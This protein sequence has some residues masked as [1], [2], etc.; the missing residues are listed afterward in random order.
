MRYTIPNLTKIMQ[1]R[2]AHR[3]GYGFKGSEESKLDALEQGTTPQDKDILRKL[4][5]KKG[6]KV[7]SIAGYYAS[8]AKE[9]QRAGA[10]VDYSD[11]SKGIVNWVKN[12][13]KVK[14]GKYLCSNYE[15]IP[16]NELEYDWTFTYEA[17]GASRG[18]S[19]AY[20]RSLLNRKGGILMIYVGE[21]RHRKANSSKMKKYPGIVQ[22]LARVYGGR[23]SVSRKRIRAHRRGKG[24]V[25]ND[26]F[27]V[28]KIRT[29]DSARK[30][31]GQDLDVLTWLGGR[32]RVD[33]S[34]ASEDL[35]LSGKE[36]G[37]SLRRLE[38]LNVVINGDNFREIEV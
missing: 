23:A 32:K 13:E 7:L 20:L 31:A 14:F 8:W 18:L 22:M 27:L 10:D 19:I 28:S 5:I 9:L 6:E 30:K 38:R 35:G 21:Q 25:R 15:L 17:C 37:N 16:E 34:R 3:V 1:P 2:W 24:E 11:I 12:H 4:G 33:L 36:I 26:L 29:N